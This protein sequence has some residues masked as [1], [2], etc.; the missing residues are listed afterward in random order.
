M[1]VCVCV[2]QYYSDEYRRLEKN[3]FQNSR[4]I[5]ENELLVKIKM[6]SYYKISSIVPTIPF[7][8]IFTSKSC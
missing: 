7:L 1:C 3:N 2:L 8:Q 5:S 4:R 6:K